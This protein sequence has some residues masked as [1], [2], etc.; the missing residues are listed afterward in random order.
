M[1]ASTLTLLE[2]SLKRAYDEQYYGGHL[3][4]NAPFFTN[5]LK[6][7][8]VKSLRQDGEGYYWPFNLQSPQNIGTP[9]EGA[10]VPVTKSRTEVQGR[11][12]LGQFVASFDISFVLESIA[13]NNVG[14]WNGG[15]IK[16]HVREC[17]TDLTKHV[18]RIYAGTH[19]TG[20]LAQV[21]AATS[22][23]TSFV[24]KL[25]IG[26]L[27]LR[28]KME[29]AIHDDDTGSGAAEDVS[30]IVTKIVQSTRTVTLTN[31]QT[32]D[33]DDHVYITGSYGAATVPNG[34]RGLVD[35]GTNLTTVHN[36]SR[37]TYEELKS[38][39]LSNSSQQRNL[40]EDLLL[41]AAH[42][43]RQRSGQYVDCVLMN[44]GQFS[45]YLSFVRPDR[46]Y[47]VSGA[48]VIQGDTGYKSAEKGYKPAAQFMHGGVTADIYVSEDVFPREVYL[49]TK[50]QLRLIE[51]GPMDWMD[52]GGTMFQQ[53]VNSTGYVTSKQA[54][55][56]YLSN[57]ATYMP[58]AHAVIV[59]LS[60]KELAGSAVGGPDT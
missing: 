9:A 4:L 35:D 20:R 34:I 19:G 43:V 5:V 40:S 46:R 2:T 24:G 26:V 33:A 59:D 55:L 32:L 44:T 30:E 39:R 10:N 50:S 29:L 54:T 48:G 8:Q 37:S 41:E 18:N 47:N 14:A 28:P 42:T 17:V 15:E 11:L 25:P 21:N 6:T 36:Q 3:N 58:S 52:W 49:L 22:S 53:G 45:K 12:R 56:L 51:N 57:I 60:D 38:V 7:N 31:A 16:R 23:S 1:A 13:K 27:L